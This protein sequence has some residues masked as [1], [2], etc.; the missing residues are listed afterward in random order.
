M[1][2]IIQDMQELRVTTAEIPNSRRFD[3]IG[4]LLFWYWFGFCCLFVYFI[5]FCF[6]GLELS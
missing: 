5:L 1:D 3:E 6:G 4:A 2:F